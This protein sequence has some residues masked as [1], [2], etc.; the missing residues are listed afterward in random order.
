MK[1][2]PKWVKSL[3]AIICLLALF[4]TVIQ[5]LLEANTKLVKHLPWSG[6]VILTFLYFYTKLLIG[7]YKNLSIVHLESNRIRLGDS[8]SFFNLFTITYSF[9]LLVI[10]LLLSAFTYQFILSSQQSSFQI[11]FI[12][13]INNLHVFTALPLLLVLAIS[14]SIVEE[15]LFRGYILDMLEK[16]FGFLASTIFTSILFAITHFAPI[17]MMVIYF[18][19][20]M[21]FCLLVKF[22]N[23]IKPAIFVHF[24]LNGL[25]FFSLLIEENLPSVLQKKE[26]DLFFLLIVFLGLFIF[27][28]LKKRKFLV[29]DRA[30]F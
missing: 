15:I 13:K 30:L 20:S 8:S 4:M 14:S 19:V 17:E 24:I 22:S 23:S 29:Q 26:T 11:D 27:L 6:V 21:G 18:L 7:K 16:Q 3:F 1:H 25:L 9:V 28:T 10:S 5:E 2:I 12:D